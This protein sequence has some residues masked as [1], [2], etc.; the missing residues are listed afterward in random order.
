MTGRWT[1]P[2]LSTG[3][4]APMFKAPTRLNP[5]FHFDTVAGRYIVLGFTAPGTAAQAAAQRALAGVRG[6]LDDLLS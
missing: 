6:R 1:L 4:F 5:N 2:P 3:E